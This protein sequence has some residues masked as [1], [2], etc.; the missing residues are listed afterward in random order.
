MTYVQ[1]FDDD[2]TNCFF[3]N[4]HGYFFKREKFFLGLLVVTTLL[5][6]LLGFG[7]GFFAQQCFVP[8]LRRRYGAVIG[9]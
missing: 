7:L 8:P 5:L 9:L 1:Y 3:P 2:R 6:L 4:V